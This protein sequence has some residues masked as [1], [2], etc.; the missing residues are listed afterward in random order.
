MKRY[1]LDESLFGRLGFVILL[2]IGALI[3]QPAEARHFSIELNGSIFGTGW[4]SGSG[5]TWSLS[6][7]EAEDRLDYFKPVLGMMGG[8]SFWYDL[9]WWSTIGVRY[10]R[11]QQGY[12][13]VQTLGVGET[14]EPG[15]TESWQIASRLYPRLKGWKPELKP[16]FT[17]GLDRTHT[18]WEYTD[19][20]LWDYYEPTDWQMQEASADFHQWSLV[21]GFGL[22]GGERNGIHSSLEWQSGIRLTES[23]HPY[24]LNQLV[25]SVGF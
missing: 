22:I 1:H 3:A 19:T 23:K 4:E 2:L 5:Y 11:G 17:V 12:G 15:P 20:L 10:T 14:V 24:S 8:A 18:S 9:T 7:P 16:F 6:G 13:L 21:L 25:F